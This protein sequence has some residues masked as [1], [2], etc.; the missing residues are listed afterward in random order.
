MTLERIVTIKMMDFPMVADSVRG[1]WITHIKNTRKLFVKKRVKMTK[2]ANIVS[3]SNKESLF[4][5]M[6]CEKV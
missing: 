4:V 1:P 5:L 2:K 3:L 6:S